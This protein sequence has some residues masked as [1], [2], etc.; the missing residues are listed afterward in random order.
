MIL[1]YFLIL[2]IDMIF[3]DFAKDF[4]IYI[5]ETFDLIIWNMMILDL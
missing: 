2:T 5:V 4:L 1:L 3:K